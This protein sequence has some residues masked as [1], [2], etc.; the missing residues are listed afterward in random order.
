MKHLWLHIRLLSVAFIWGLGWTAGRVVATD[1]PLITAAL[2][3]YIIAITLFLLWLKSTGNMRI[4]TKQ[5]WKVL[6]YIGFFS[7]FVYQVFFMFGMKYTAAGD[8]SLMITFNPI[9][10]ALLAVPFLGEKMTKRL[11]IGLTLAL[12]GVAILFV[13]SPNV[14]I[15]V[16]TRMLGDVLIILAAFA[17]ATSTIFMK[18][19]MTTSTSDSNE[20]LSPLQL[21]VWASVAGFFILIPW[22][23]YELIDGGWPEFNQEIILSIVFLAVFST[24]ISYVWFAEGIQTIGANRAALYVYLVPPFGIL[25]GWW[26]L[27]EQLGLSLVAAFVLIVGGVAIAQSEKHDESEPS[28]IIHGD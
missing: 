17:W 15:P 3:R 21:T 26:L 19:A 2:I 24:V 8:A 12:S 22:S 6:F 13:Y 27:D 14:D 28:G 18:K 9:I 5:E 4:P 25:S 7:T 20:P 23:S 11:A 1:F 16:A 10:T